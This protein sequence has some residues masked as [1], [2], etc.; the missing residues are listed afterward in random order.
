ML[1]NNKIGHSLVVVG[2]SFSRPLW[3]EEY[4]L[5]RIHLSL[6]QS[7]GLEETTLP[8]S[9]VLYLDCYVA[10]TKDGVGFV[11]GDRNSIIWC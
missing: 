11:A 5:D 6:S 4:G 2:K 1:L 7:L 8:I 10:V 9:I 3:G